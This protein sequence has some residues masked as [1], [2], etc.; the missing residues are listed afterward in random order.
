MA[1]FRHLGDLLD[2]FDEGW[3]R[4]LQYS[5]SCVVLVTRIR[6]TRKARGD[7]E[8]IAEGAFTSFTATPFSTRIYI[9]IRAVKYLRTRNFK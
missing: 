7:K 1:K 4:E 9:H 8:L 6:V 3:A 5:C 2:K